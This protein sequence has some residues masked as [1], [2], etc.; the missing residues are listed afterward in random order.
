MRRAIWIA[1]VPI[2][3]IYVV[4]AYATLDRRSNLDQISALVQQGIQA[5]QDRNVTAAVSCI[6]P[7]YSDDAGF[8]YDRLRFVLGK[9]MNSEPDYVLTTSRPVVRTHGD[10][11]DVTLHVVVKHPVGAIIYDRDVTLEL[12]KDRSYHM[13][14]IPTRRWLVVGTKNLGLRNDDSA[15]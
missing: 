7:N 3:L 10:Q 12:A 9:A 2:V 8:N 6:S 13:L 4:V 11:A 5:V 14:I 1:V 15:F